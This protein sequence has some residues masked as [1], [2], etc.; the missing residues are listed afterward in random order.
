MTDDAG[1]M[2]AANSNEDDIQ[3]AISGDTDSNDGSNGSGLADS[4]AGV[5]ES[6]EPDLAGKTE[7]RPDG[8]MGMA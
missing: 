5:F 2:G 3:D 1:A 7:R 6:D 4:A 8:E